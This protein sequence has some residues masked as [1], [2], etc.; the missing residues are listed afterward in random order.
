MQQLQL[1]LDAI[2][3]HMNVYATIIDHTQCTA[4]TKQPYEVTCGD[5]DTEC[6][7]GINISHC[8]N[9]FALQV[10]IFLLNSGKTK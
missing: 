4:A 6:S 3:V 1:Q 5:Q 10:C 7:F 2:I 9:R 8:S